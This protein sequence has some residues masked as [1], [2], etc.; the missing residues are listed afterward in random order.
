MEILKKQNRRI[1]GTVEKKDDDD[2]GNFE[3]A[4]QKKEE[5]ERDED[6]DFEN[7]EERRSRKR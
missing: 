7:F 4:K 5:V 2:F 1:K 6:D 3:E